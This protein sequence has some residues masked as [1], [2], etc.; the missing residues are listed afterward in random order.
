MVAK[1]KTLAELAEMVDGKLSGNPETVIHG[2]SDLDSA[3]P[4][5]ISFL[6][7]TAGH[8]KLKGSR[9]SA[10]IVPKSLE[11]D[12]KPLIRVANPYLA[13][14]HIQ[15]FFE[16][17]PF[18]ATGVSPKADIGKDCD[19][20]AEISIGSFVCIGNRVKLGK[21][22]TI[23]PGVVIGDDV[24]IGED[25]LLY[26][27]VTVY[28]SCTI[29]SRVIIHSGTVVGSD[30]FGFAT[31]ETGSHI[32]RPHVGTVQID[33]DVEIGANVCIDRATFGKTHIMS[34]TKMD[35][36]I[37]IG[38]NVK[39]GENSLIVA[40]V[41]IAGSAS[42]GKNVVLGGQSAVKGHIHL[43]DGVMVAGKSGVHSSVPKGSI[44]SGYPAIPHKDWLKACA[45]FAKLPKV[46][47]ELLEM[48]SKIEAVYEKLF[49]T[50]GHD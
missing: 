47:G 46:Y 3:D 42:L 29:G 1:T 20:P 7:K 22:S 11:Y 13:A 49:P 38:H 36:L 18:E 45:I 15:N 40:Q 41:G 27:N 35:N 48:K 28:H 5:E 12:D 43:D 37:Q 19:I 26:P 24:I 21:R 44:V 2:L 8:D 4:G 16:S 25:C 9:A 33:D 30:G 10:F 31:D 6:V 50:E 32:K 39:I 34:G 23:H 17:K 14:A